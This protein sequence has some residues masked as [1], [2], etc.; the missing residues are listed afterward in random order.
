MDKLRYGYCRVSRAA[1]DLARNLDTQQQA[2]EAVGI[3]PEL[4]YRDVASGGSLDRR[5]WNALV[6]AVRPGD[7]ITV[8]HLDRIGRNLVEGL[9]AI[10]R[11]TEQGV[12]I[13]ALDV[14]IDTSAAN[15]A[16][17][18]QIAMMLAFAEWERQTIRERSVA[19]QIRA[20]EAGKTI[21][22]PEAL[23]ESAKA[24]IRL[25]HQQGRS[26][27]RLAEDYH[28]ARSTIYRAIAGAG[29]DRPPGY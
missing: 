21:G 24:D 16:A 18:L 9:Q 2:L 12:G 19:G 25:L 20:R 1:D 27:T 15:P 8:S 4:I 5:G 23:T 11:L 13:V 28:V 26:A 3:R 6:D 10:E 22:R 7:T 29:P 17:R 14:G